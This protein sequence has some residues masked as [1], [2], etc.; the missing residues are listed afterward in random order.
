MLSRTELLGGL[1]FV[2]GAALIG[3]GPAIQGTV[4]FAIGIGAVFGLSV[5]TILL[6]TAVETEPVREL[7]SD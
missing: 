6:G 5:G 7:G 3:A 2:V 1:L 4:G